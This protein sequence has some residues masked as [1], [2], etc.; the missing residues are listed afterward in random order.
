MG[1]KLLI[2]IHFLRLFQ[3]YHHSNCS[4]SM[5]CLSIIPYG[6]WYVSTVNEMLIIMIIDI[7]YH[8][9]IQEAEKCNMQPQSL[10]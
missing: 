8:T 10:N 4:H 1:Y 6:V 3:Y 9:V 7:L 5:S 2:N